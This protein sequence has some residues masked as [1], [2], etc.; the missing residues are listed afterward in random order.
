MI[1]MS[2]KKQMTA[3]AAG[4]TAQ[5]TGTVPRRVMALSLKSTIR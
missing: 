1:Q 3:V 4:K 5:K 2:L